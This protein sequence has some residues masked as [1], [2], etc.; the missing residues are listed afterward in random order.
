[1]RTEK[2]KDTSGKSSKEFHSVDFFRKVKEKIAKKLEGKSFEEQK[3]IIQK[4]LSGEIEI[5]G[6]K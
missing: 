5:T 6:I 1:M 4:I 2:Q 3:E